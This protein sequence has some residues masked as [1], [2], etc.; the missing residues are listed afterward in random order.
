MDHASFIQYPNFPATI[1][2]KGKLRVAGV[3]KP[4]GRNPLLVGDGLLDSPGKT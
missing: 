1:H 2:G 4:D 3:S